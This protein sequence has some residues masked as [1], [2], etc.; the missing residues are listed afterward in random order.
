MEFLE[1][2]G[3][4]VGWMGIWGLFLLQTVILGMDGQWVPT[5]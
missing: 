4:G 5:I 2:G 1:R 3:E